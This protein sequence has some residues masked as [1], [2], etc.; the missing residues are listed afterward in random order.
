[1]EVGEYRAL[2][3]ATARDKQMAKA[4]AQAP[5]GEGMRVVE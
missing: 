4:A 5:E 1:V 2:L 3:L